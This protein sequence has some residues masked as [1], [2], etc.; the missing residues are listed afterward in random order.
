MND[1]ATALR[2]MMERRRTDDATKEPTHCVPTRTIAVT[3]G[4]GGVGKTNIALNLAIALAQQGASVCILDANLGLGNV[5][6]LCGLSAYWNLSHVVTGARSLSE[7]L[8]DGPGNIHVVPGASGLNDLADCPEA[9]RH[10]ILEQMEDLERNH[11][12]LI[13]DTGSGIHESV[14]QFALAADTIMIVTTPEPTSIADAYALIKSV[15][16]ADPPQLHVVVNQADSQSHARSILTR[17]QQTS[18]MFLKTDVIAEGFIPR[19]D[20]V[21]AAV[22]NRIPFVLNSPQTAASKQIHRLAHAQRVYSERFFGDSA[23]LSGERDQDKQPL[24]AQSM[25]GTAGTMERKASF[26]CRVWQRL[27]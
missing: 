20:N 1:Q 25:K 24:L 26:F 16:A 22:L 12:F 18:R 10:E 27:G 23:P 2:S 8:L 6:L 21:P 5:D 14:R 19:D 17:L 7:I 11:D 4:K 3:S 9:A 15:S 13:I